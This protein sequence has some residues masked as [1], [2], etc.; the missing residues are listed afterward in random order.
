MILICNTPGDERQRF[1]ERDFDLP[2]SIYNFIIILYQKRRKER[3]SRKVVNERERDGRNIR[4]LTLA[5]GSLYLSVRDD[6]RHLL[7]K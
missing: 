7:R 4:V 6:D 1:I 2:M 5:Y 3:R